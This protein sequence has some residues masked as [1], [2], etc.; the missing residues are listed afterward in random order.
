MSYA[1]FSVLVLSVAA[2]LPQI[3]VIVGAALGT[4]ISYNGHR[5]FAFAPT[6]DPA[7][8]RSYPHAR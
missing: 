5:L 7:K 1:V 3:A 6:T 4:V 2:R 8:T